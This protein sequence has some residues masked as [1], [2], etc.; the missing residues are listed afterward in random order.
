MMQICNYTTKS[1]L[2]SHIISKYFL[3]YMKTYWLVSHWKEG[4][5]LS[6]M[7]TA[8]VFSKKC[9]Q[10]FWFHQ[11]KQGIGRK[12]EQWTYRNFAKTL[13]LPTCTISIAI[14]KV[15]QNRK[16]DMNKERCSDGQS[17]HYVLTTTSWAAAATTSPTATRTSTSNINIINIINNNNNNN[18]PYGITSVR[19]STIWLTCS[20]KSFRCHGLDLC[21]GW[22]P[23]RAQ[24]MH[25]LLHHWHQLCLSG[26]G[27]SATH[28]ATLMAPLQDH[29]VLNTEHSDRTIEVNSDK[30]LKSGP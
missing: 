18:S 15:L 3:Y 19:S 10:N 26:A 7:G 28:T 13:G 9:F 11:Q 1:S 16:N 4:L 14:S 8:I 25:L 30:M 6:H 24:Q 12:G 27:H 21:P 29:A 23:Q 17:H 20:L 2:Y 22:G 5:N